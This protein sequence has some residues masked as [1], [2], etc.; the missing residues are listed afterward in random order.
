MFIRQGCPYCITARKAISDLKQEYSRYSDIPIQMIDEELHPDTADQ[1]S[2]YYV[3]SLFIDN[4]KYYEC[5]PGDSA[6]TIKEQI[7]KTLDA[8][9]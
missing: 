9:A 3:P 1:Y 2:Y 4:Q 5:M 6:D 7:R 8:A